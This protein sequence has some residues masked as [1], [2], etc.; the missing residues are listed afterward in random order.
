MLQRNL[1]PSENRSNVLYCHEMRLLLQEPTV[2]YSLF[3]WVFFGAPKNIYCFSSTISGYDGG[4]RTRNIECIPG[5][6]AH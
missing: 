4:N 3:F 6:L 2:Q 1:R 5:A